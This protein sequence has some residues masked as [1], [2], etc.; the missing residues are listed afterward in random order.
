[1]F[2][3]P[4]FGNVCS[5]LVGMKTYSPILGLSTFTSTTTSIS[6]LQGSWPISLIYKVS[7]ELSSWKRETS[8][9]HSLSS[10]SLF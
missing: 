5:E 9:S 1:M 10:A 4:T 2:I 3:Y 6:L 8:R 7:P